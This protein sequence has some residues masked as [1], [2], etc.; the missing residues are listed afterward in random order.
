MA[1]GTRTGW[2][3]AKETDLAKPEWGLKRL[4][5]SCGARFYDLKR[6]P[7]TCPKCGA[8]LE[9]EA[10][11]RLKRSRSAPPSPAKA[12]PEAAEEENALEIE[13]GSDLEDVSDED[14]DSVLE[15]ASDLNASDD[16]DG[17]AGGVEKEKTED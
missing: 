13:G 5:A 11:P 9:Q 15:D 1:I 14:D 17:I 6:D 3:G 12:K 10:S 8:V 16:L 4:C 7:I 2:G